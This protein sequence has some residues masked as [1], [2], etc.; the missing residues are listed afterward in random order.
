VKNTFLEMKEERP[1][2]FKSRRCRSQDPLKTQHQYEC[3][4]PI[5]DQ[6]VDASTTDD[7]TSC[8]VPSGEN[9]N[10]AAQQGGEISNTAAQQG[11]LQAIR[12]GDIPV[13]HPSNR[14]LE[15]FNGLG[16]EGKIDPVYL[17]MDFREEK[18]MGSA[19]D[20][21][22]AEKLMKL[23]PIDDQGV[24]GST[25]DDGTTCSVTSD[26]N[27]NMAAQQGGKFSNTAA[28]QGGRQAVRVGDIPVSY[29]SNQM[30][31]VI[32][33]LG[34][35]GKIDFF[36]LPMDFKKKQPMGAAFVNLIDHASA[37]EFMKLMQERQWE[38]E[39]SNKAHGKSNWINVY[40]DSGVNHPK[41]PAEFKPRLFD[42]A[43]SE[44][45]FPASEKELNLPRALRHR[46]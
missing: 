33:G 44:E 16:S 6:G 25:T 34:L 30:L 46:N 20:H 8:S 31:E 43:G 4:T 26:E 2:H 15:V 18:S 12:A 9:C 7:D 36:Y 11:G 24:D 23:M 29:T 27:C 35:K 40:R 14:L 19:I 10:M 39:W 28:Q 45:K 22:S 17:P 5:E 37:E 13:S 3:R 42:R 1:L 21:A 41:V 32:N 38:V